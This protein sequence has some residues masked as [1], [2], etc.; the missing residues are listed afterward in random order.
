MGRFTTVQDPYIT[1]RGPSLRCESCG[2][3]TRERKPFCPEHVG[4]NDRAG[5]LF[6]KLAAVEKEIESVSKGGS[7]LVNVK[8]LVVEE[9]MAGIA[10]AGQL[11][12]VRLVKDHVPFFNG[13]AARTTKFYL[14]RLQAEELVC[15]EHNTRGI[16]IV[17][18]TPEGLQFVKK[19]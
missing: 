3:P 14:H 11:T 19:G 16:Q 9:I 18:L 15:V 5:M 1:T 7:R 13:V 4:L 8:G 17:G 12:W 6:A 2:E 10:H